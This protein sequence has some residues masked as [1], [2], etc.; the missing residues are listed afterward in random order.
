MAQSTLLSPRNA[1]RVSASLRVSGRT[2]WSG[3]VTVWYRDRSV[4][5]KQSQMHTINLGNVIR[6]LRGE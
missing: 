2:V 3:I 5:I 1:Q 6:Q 4:V